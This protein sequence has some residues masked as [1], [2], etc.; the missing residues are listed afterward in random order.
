MMP[1][2]PGL[3]SLRTLGQ[4]GLAIPA[5]E[6]ALFVALLSVFMLLG[7]AQL[8]LIV[9][10]LFVLYWGFVCFWPTFFEAARGDAL[11]LGVYLLCG[12]A[13]AFLVLIAFFLPSD[14]RL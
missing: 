8:G 5:W 12:V 11:A 4:V 7:R 1:S 2:D 13:L 3:A 6:M 10:Y 9:T 14:G